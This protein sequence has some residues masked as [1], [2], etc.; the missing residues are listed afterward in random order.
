MVQAPVPPEQDRPERGA[1]RPRDVVAGGPAGAERPAQRHRWDDP[2]AEPSHAP[3]VT[4]A[5]D[6]ADLVR[7][8][9]MVLRDVPE[10]MWTRI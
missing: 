7:R 1:R 4:S 2:S 3:P 6:D 8:F 9:E 10:G 5:V